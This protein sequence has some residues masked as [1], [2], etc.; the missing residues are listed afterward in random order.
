[1]TPDTTIFR[2]SFLPLFWKPLRTAYILGILLVIIME[3]TLMA[4]GLQTRWPHL[5]FVFAG[6]ILSMAVL[7]L[8]ITPVFILLFPTKQ[9]PAGVS[10]ATCLGK[11]YFLRWDEIK[12][13][14]LWI[15]PFVRL[16]YIQIS[17]DRTKRPLYIGWFIRRNREFVELVRKNSPVENP[18]R[19]CLEQLMGDVGSDR[20]V[21]AERRSMMSRLADAVALILIV[22]A[23]LV[24][25]RYAINSFRAARFRATHTVS[26]GHLNA[27]RY[28]MPAVTIADEMFVIGG[29]GSD[30]YLGDVERFTP[31]TGRVHRTFPG[32]IKRRYHTAEAFEGKIYILGGCGSWASFPDELEIYDPSDGSIRHGSPIPTTRYLIS[33]VVHDGKIYVVGGTPAVGF[34]SGSTASPDTPGSQLD[35][36]TIQTN[37]W[38]R[39]APMP[40][41]RQCDVVARGR[42]IYAIGGYNG[43]QAIRSFESYDIDSNQ[44]ERLPDM[45]F[46]VSAHRC[47]LVEDRIVCFGDHAKMDRVSAYDFRTSRWETLEIGYH[48]RRHV[49]VTSVEDTVYVVGGNA[50]SPGLDDIQAFPI[51]AFLQS[52]R[53]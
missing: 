12:N 4:A 48:P 9:T 14:K 6:A 15:L 21:D 10:T 35:I 39:G 27:G 30:G 18:L 42:K 40:T 49:A 8:I 45:P 17:S 7:A 28:G 29:D 46:A 47:V 11:N 31:A 3:S 16:E 36:Y 53:N 20:P 32:L 24:L 13:A 41:A 25:A 33:S 52:S 34:F 19:K 1:M 38:T 22:G 44:W 5:L 23:L 51:K 37:R 43:A 2:D 26:F 50:A